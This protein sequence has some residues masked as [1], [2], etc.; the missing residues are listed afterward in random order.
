MKAQKK[1]RKKN[2]QGIRPLFRV[3]FVVLLPKRAGKL[4]HDDVSRPRSLQD[5]FRGSCKKGNTSSVV[6]SSWTKKF[7]CGL[8]GIPLTSA[9]TK[10]AA[11]RKLSL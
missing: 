6:L 10:P 2:N 5:G 11:T 8:R 9:D 7:T 1:K 3:G 4:G